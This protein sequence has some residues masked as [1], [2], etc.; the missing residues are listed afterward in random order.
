MSDLYPLKFKTIYLDKIWGG[1]RLKTILNKDYGQLPNCGESWEISGVEGNIS[2]VDNGFLA[3][4]NL[5]E[6]IEI[7]M[8]DLVGDKV[9]EQ[10]GE[11]FPL[12]IK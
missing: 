12:L 3:G 7:Y 6:L 9:F 8:G 2:V 5:Q 11:E 4:N 10:F 1:N